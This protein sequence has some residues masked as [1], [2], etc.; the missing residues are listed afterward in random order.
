MDRSDVITK[1]KFF[2]FMGFQ[3]F[4][5]MGLRARASVRAPPARGAPLLSGRLYYGGNY[6]REI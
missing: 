1:P 4:L 2:A 5:A 3:I 6:N